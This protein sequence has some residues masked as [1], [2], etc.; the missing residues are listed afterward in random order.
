MG[1]RKKL[2]IGS[3]FQKVESMQ[4]SR[5]FFNLKYHVSQ[6]K[7]CVCWKSCSCSGSK[8]KKSTLS[9]LTTRSG[10][11]GEGGWPYFLFHLILIMVMIWV[12][13]IFSL[14]FASHSY[15]LQ[16]PPLTISLN[17]FGRSGA[18]GKAL[19]TNLPECPK[20][21]LGDFAIFSVSL[22]LHDT[23]LHTVSSWWPESLQKDR[24]W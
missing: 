1:L 22:S 21:S 17:T 14:S 7:I 18:G 4:D 23:S 19:T 9:C 5:N 3:Q 10:T 15:C 13:H 20:S 11:G 2:Y 24:T 6:I 12:D 8:K 16:V